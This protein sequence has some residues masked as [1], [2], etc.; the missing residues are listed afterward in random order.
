MSNDTFEYRGNSFKVEIE[1]D[2]LAPPWIE[3]G[4]CGPV[5]EWTTRDKR[6]GEWVLCEDR[7]YKRF[8]DFAEAMKKAK[9]EAWDAPPYSEVTKGERALRAV[10]A[11]FEHLRKWC[12]GDW[13][14]ITLHVTLL[15]EFEEETEYD[16]CLGG[17][18]YDFSSNGYWMI[19]AR[20]MAAEI[21]QRFE[22][23]QLEERLSK[24][25][26]QAMECGL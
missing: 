3:F 15:N 20:E 16:D 26:K 7:G 17:I 4:N 22:K 13:I 19:D 12:N 9:R 1:Q 5:S 2:D 11:D 23:D 14:Y 18:E 25:F 6:P 24:R 8:Y 21:L 10:T